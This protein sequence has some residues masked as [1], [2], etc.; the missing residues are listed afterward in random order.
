MKLKKAVSYL[1]VAAMAVTVLGG[2]G[3]PGDTVLAAEKNLEDEHITL[4]LMNTT[5]EEA[6]VAWEDSM[7]EG[8]EELHP[9]ITIEVQ[10]MGYDDYIQTIQTKFASGDAPDIYLIETAYIPLYVENGYTADLTGADFFSQFNEKDLEML[11]QDGKVYAVPYNSGTMCVTYN[12]DVFA[13][14]GITEI[15]KTLD[16]F[17]QVCDKLKEAGIIPLANGYQESWCV[18]ADLQGDYISDVLMNDNDAIKR[19][20]SREDRFTES[21]A[22]R[23]VFERLGQRYQYIEDD[24]FGTDWNTACTLIANGDAAMTVNGNWASNNI[25]AMNDSVDLGV[26]A[27]PTTNDASKTKLTIQPPTGGYAVNGG[28]VNKE[29]A[30]EFLKYYTSTDV[31]V[32][33]A[34]NVDSICLVKGVEIEGGGALADIMAL[35]NDG[36][37]QS[38]GAVDHNF[39]NEFRVALET[40]ASQFLLDGGTDVDSVLQTLD[41]EFDRIAED[42]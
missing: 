5:L 15:P 28:C 24:A 16:D 18:M 4:T 32:T 23:G 6:T 25:K 8:F 22:W 12:K 41:E 39:P 37:S 21:D 17:Y 20:V 3:Q 36:Q 33:Y 10:R 38:L 14:A 42:N 11:S 31:A 1:A 26:F 9:N 34:E 2:A 35:I 7:I 30:M 29:A 27:L 40:S 13:D 19:L